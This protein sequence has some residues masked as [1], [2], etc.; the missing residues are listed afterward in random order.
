MTDQ[1]K[2]PHL[3]FDIY[4]YLVAHGSDPD[5]IQAELI[6][7]TKKIGNL[8]IMQ[9]APE[10]GRFMTLLAKMIGAKRAIEVGTF[11]GY[12]AL[13]TARGLTDDGYLLC[14]DTSDEWTDIAKRYW[15]KAGVDHKIDLKIAPALDTL[16][17][18]PDDRNFDIAF[19]D[20]DKTNQQNYYEEIL[21]RTRS[22]GLILLDNTLMSGKVVDPNVSKGSVRAMRECND[23]IAQD[24]RVESVMLPIAD[25]LTLVRVI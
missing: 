23:F 7:E 18:L 12:S 10:Q 6:S 19:I 2:T 15:K 25:G 16:K 8:A 1:R 4:D 9:I 11:T 17:A 21:K 13:C 20:A 22:G 14:C 5:E 24:K 3:P